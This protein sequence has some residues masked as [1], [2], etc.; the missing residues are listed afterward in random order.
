MSYSHT[1]SHI[2][3]NITPVFGKDELFS[4][5]VDD[6]NNKYNIHRDVS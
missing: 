6:I 1:M 2:K 4:K 5:I 3:A